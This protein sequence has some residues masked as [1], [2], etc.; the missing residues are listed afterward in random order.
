METGLVHLHNLLRWVILIFLLLSVIKSF[1]AWR[2]RRAFVPGDKKL[3]LMTM[4]AAH[5]TL[6]LGI[7]QVL[8]GRYGIFTTELPAGK[9]VMQDSFYRFFWVEHPVAMIIGIV[10]ITLGYGMSKKAVSDEVKFRKAFIY[11]LLALVVILAAI[12]WDRPLMPGMG[13]E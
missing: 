10:L 1:S 11:F 6:L 12:P 8:V 13:A 3:W 5:T 7:F 2:S 4:I 9:S